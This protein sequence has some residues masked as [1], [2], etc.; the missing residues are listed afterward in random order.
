MRKPN[1]SERNAALGVLRDADRGQCSLSPEERDCLARLAMAAMM[2]E[3]LD[4]AAFDSVEAAMERARSL[5][6]APV[7]TEAPATP[8]SRVAR[9]RLA[10]RRWAATA[11]R[12]RVAMS[13]AIGLAAIIAPIFMLGGSSPQLSQ[14]QRLP[15][16]GATTA[17]LAA[18]SGPGPHAQLVALQQPGDHAAGACAKP[19]AR[20]L[21]DAA[22]HG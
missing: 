3:C 4:D 18:P 11:R 10:G 22:R 2:D 15:A 19:G 16:L 12:P 6:S 1:C 20:T 7:T 9:V 17:C 14:A 8:D 21:S 5:G 13:A